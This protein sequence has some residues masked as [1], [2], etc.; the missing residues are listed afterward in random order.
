MKTRFLQIVHLIALTFLLTV[1]SF[2]QLFGQSPY[3]SVATGNWN[4]D[5][6][7]SGTGVPVAGDVVNIANGHTVTVTVAAAC[8][9]ITFTGAAATLTVNNGITLTVSGN[10]TLNNA[11]GTNN[12]CTISGSG[13]LSCA[14]VVVGGTTTNLSADRTTIMT[15]TISGLSISGNLNINGEDDVND[16]NNATFALQSGS[17]TINGSVIL[18]DENNDCDAILTL[19]SGAQTGTLTL[20]GSTPFIITTSPT[21][22]ANG[23]SATVVYSGA[24][25]TVYPVAYFNLTLSGSG[26]K[27]LTGVGTINGNLTLSGTATAA[28][29]AALTVGGNLTVGSGTTFATGATN[30][31]TLAVTGTTSLTGT[32]TLANTGTKTFTGNVTIN[33]GGIWN[34]TGVAP[35][36]YEGNLQND[37][38]YT[39]NTGVHTFSTASNIISGTNVIAIPNLTISG[40]TT[41]NGTLTV[42]S[43]LAG[44]STLTNGANATLNFGGSSI[45]PTLIATANPNT[46][47]FN[48]TA[49]TVKAT[50]Y[51]N[52]ILSGSGVKTLTLVST[53]NGDFT[54]SGSAT[55]A[56]ATTF[57]VS[58]TTTASGT[59]TLT[60]GSANILSNTGAV[61]LDGGTFKTGAT[62]GY[63]ETIGVLSMSASSTIALGTGN[64]TLTIA[65]SS[66]ASWTGTLSITGWTSGTNHIQ[67]GVGGL[68][69]TQLGLVS[70]S[71]YST[72]AIIS[73]SGELFPRNNWQAQF[74][75]MSAGSSSWC[76]GET[77]TVTVSVK[78]VGLSTWT[79]ASPDINVGIKWN[80]DPDYL[81]RTDANG[82]AP[83]A[84]QTYSLT[85]TA[86][87]TSASNNLTFDVVNEGACWFGNNNGTCGPG[88]TVFTSSAI[89]VYLPPVALGATNFAYNS[90]SANW[91]AS[92]GAT[93]YH[94]DVS[95]ESNFASFLTGYNDLDVSNVT[96]YPVSGVTY[97]TTYYY[98]VR[99]YTANCTGENSNTITVATVNTGDYRSAATGNWGTLA[100]WQR[101]SGTT[102]ATPTAGQ[103][104][105]TNTS[106][107]TIIR[108]PHVVSIAANVT[109]DQVTVETGGQIIVSSGNT[110]TIN[111]GNGVD[112][113]VFGTLQTNS[114][115]G[116]GGFTNNG[117]IAIGNGG[118][119][120]YNINS[121]DAIP[122]A[123]WDASS[124]CLITGTTNSVPGG[125][126]QSFGN[127]TWNCAS[128]SATIVLVGNLT[129]ISG[130][131]TIVNTNGQI[132]RGSE[133]V[134]YILNIGGDFIQTGGIFDFHGTNDNI[135]ES[136]N[137]G[138]SFN[139]T[140]GT[141][142]RSNNTGTFTFNF[143]GSNKTFTQTGTLTNTFI[144]WN[145]NSGASILLNNDLPVAAS[146]TCVVNGT[147]DCGVS[148][149]VSG[150]GAFTLA[151]GG[152]LIIGSPNGITSGATLSGNVQTTGGRTFNT[153]ANYVYNGAGTQVSGNGLPI[154][155]NSLTVSG[156]SYLTLTNPTLASPLTVTSGCT[157]NSGAKLTIGSA[158]GMTV[159]GTLTN[160]AG[161]A[162]L[163]IKSDNS[164][165][166]S[167]ISSTTDVDA[168]VER[169]LSKMV[170]HFIGMPV[171]SGVAGVFHLP[172]GHADIYLKTHIEA[173]NT[174][175]PWIVPV[176]TPLI[177]G[178]GYEC[179]VGDPWVPANQM[180][181]TVVFPGKLGAGNY[182]TGSGS[183]YTLEYTTGHGLNLIC[184][185]YPSALQANIHTWTKTNISN[186][187]YIWDPGYGNYRYW[188]GTSGTPPPY[189]GYGTLTSGVIPE[190][191]AFFVEVT[192]SNPSLTIPQS[193]RIHS[194]QAYYK[195][196][197]IPVNTLRLDIEGN[198][199]MDAI[200]VNFNE[201]STEGYDPDYD[202]E[203]MYGLDEAPQLYSSIAGKNLSIN[204]IP[205]L[206]ENRII[207]IGFECEVS[208]NFTIATSGMEGFTENVEFYLEDLKE[209][210]VQNLKEIPEYT[211]TG[212]SSD[213]PGRFLL[214]FANPNSIGESIP[215]PVSIYADNNTIH[216]L[217]IGQT[218]AT[219][220]V[221]D[222]M[223]RQI[224]ETKIFGEKTAAIKVDAETG[225]YLVKVQTS[226]QFV[227]EKVFIK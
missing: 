65:N 214:H 121:I 217:N 157:I 195:D 208:T 210:I 200:F 42:S 206:D 133:T 6:T 43:T 185:P 173:T 14:S 213:E 16:D 59:S 75:S 64:H 212:S 82:L 18:D 164:G 86:P 88:N 150:S 37:G 128:Q 127:F 172:S 94:L 11:A 134:A 114:T 110:L 135:S 178:R 203:K 100:T 156:T 74:I 189:T 55:A 98:R 30:T 108:S 84:T 209:G 79:D 227:T 151:N 192:G 196:S 39:A 193:D 19:A 107:I 46:I 197:E 153:G 207:P 226:D 169:F 175:G 138:G 52:L 68:T 204:S 160:N 73:A 41:N 145:I 144:N 224:K 199:Y 22:T 131:F 115:S 76:S 27:T 31:W 154:T 93:G 26:I 50:T 48:G 184:N 71:G 136:V 89:T 17:V 105:P 147:L 72:G 116:T 118:T 146:R 187:V 2:T 166:G 130:N 191:Q 168:K 44:T 109:V 56:P 181:E 188:N 132:L 225:Y 69:D 47:N 141:F 51:H 205:T 103:G 67:V 140:G 182:T 170:W 106:G 62:T 120:I 32:L 165:T 159:N 20:S 124:T 9:S 186:K 77:R 29:A 177:Q 202:V 38:T 117:Q 33:S 49:Q 7:W 5:A 183:F 99:A 13:T 85:V 198:G 149:K 8:A 215:N 142:N 223:G 25:Q 54:L 221:Y 23:T 129:S 211:F 194:S 66:A 148:T 80:A 155:I 12:A 96:T 119:F 15:S 162:G 139:Q 87:S 81:V 28:T 104:T 10:V 45:T 34:E 112:L 174:W 24:S 91:N 83:G 111:N 125:L 171:T 61:T 40:T 60:L 219:V 180:D 163:L 4:A 101:W 123:T 137:L 222:L 143:T 179:W 152:T 161:E 63:N 126:N 95:T 1:G 122:T 113:N 220:H 216:I 167:L 218:M 92:T 36:D 158:Q 53:I 58:G 3:T 70:F 90:F 201:L 102:W 78:N 35:I 176:G 190:M 57:T 97:G 21:F